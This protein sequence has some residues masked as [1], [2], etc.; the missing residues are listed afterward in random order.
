MLERDECERKPVTNGM[1]SLLCEKCGL[2]FK[3]L[4]QLQDHISI[5]HNKI[6]QFLCSQCPKTYARK[7][8]LSDHIRSHSLQ[9]DFICTICA[10]SFR[11]SQELSRHKLLHQEIKNYRCLHCGATFRQHS[12]LYKHMRTKHVLKSNGI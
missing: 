7:T 10:K 12:G 4:H 8:H 5:T 3:Y 11:R 6:R 1:D 2:K 9:R